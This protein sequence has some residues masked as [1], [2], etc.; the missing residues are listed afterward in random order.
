M[1]LLCA[2]VVLSI[3]S[4]TDDSSA[5]W[6]P[7]TAASCCVTFH[8][9]GLLRSMFCNSGLW[10]VLDEA[11][12]YIRSVLEVS[13]MLWCRHKWLSFGLKTAAMVRNTNWRRELMPYT[14]MVPSMLP[15][16]VHYTIG[17]SDMIFWI[18][19][20]LGTTTCTG[21]GFQFLVMYLLG[22]YGENMCGKYGGDCLTCYGVCGK[23]VLFVHMTDECTWQAVYGD[24]LL[25]MNDCM[26]YARWLH[27][28]MR[29]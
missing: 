26:C 5:C 11:G 23:A 15:C 24:S 9:G 4:H 19:G 7:P 13:E 16:I 18:V 1:G 25:F 14:K 21:P 12:P 22:E 10:S 3:G 29:I 8:A 28:L 17:C 6:P 2:C 20:E 27:R